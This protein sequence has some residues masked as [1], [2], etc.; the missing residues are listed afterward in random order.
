MKWKPLRKSIMFSGPIRPSFWGSGLLLAAAAV[1]E[2]SMLSA[3][4]VRG[5]GACI[6]IVGFEKRRLRD[7]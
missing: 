5:A 4:V 7:N 3:A 1:L 2:S 6:L